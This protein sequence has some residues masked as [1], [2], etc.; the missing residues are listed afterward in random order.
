MLLP[1]SLRGHGRCNAVRPAALYFTSWLQGITLRNTSRCA[2]AIFF[3]LRSDPDGARHHSF[4]S[5]FLRALVP[6]PAR[7]IHEARNT[8]HE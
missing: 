1:A 7:P 2:S 3:L 6:R 5:I 4:D 8:C